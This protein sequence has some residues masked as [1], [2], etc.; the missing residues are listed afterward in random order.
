MRTLHILI[1]TL[2]PSSVFA[3]P[4]HLDLSFGDHR[5][6]IPSYQELFSE[7]IQQQDGKL[8]TASCKSDP[9]FGDC[10]FLVTRY[11]IDGSID[12]SFNETGSITITNGSGG[13]SLIAS[14]E[15]IKQQSD[16][17]LIVLGYFNG[18]TGY[19]LKRFNTDGSLDTTF[20]SIGTVSINTP[21]YTSLIIGY[22]MLQADGNIVISGQLNSIGSSINHLFLSRYLPDGIMD[23]SFGNNGVVLKQQVPMGGITQP[24]MQQSDGKIIVLH[25]YISGGADRFNSDGSSDLAFGDNGYAAGGLDRTTAML[26]QPDGKIIL[27]GSNYGVNISITRINT[28]GTTDTDFGDN[29]FLN[30]ILDDVQIYARTGVL[31]PNGKIIAVAANSHDK[32]GVTLVRINPDGTLDTGFD[33]D[34]IMEVKQLNPSAQ[35]ID[36]NLSMIQSDSRLLIAGM[37][38]KAGE[39][40]GNGYIARILTDEEDYTGDDRNNEQGKCVTTADMDGDGTADLIVG[41]PFA[42]ATVGASTIKRAGTIKIISGKDHTI[43]RRIKGSISNENLGSALAS[44]PDQDSDNIPDIL[45][46]EPKQNRVSLYSGAT[47]ER[48]KTLIQVTGFKQFGAAIATGDVTND[49]IADIVIGAPGSNTIMLYDGSTVFNPGNPIPLYSR[50]GEPGLFGA[51]VAI[52]K[53]KRLL[54]GSPARKIL[55]SITGRYLSNAG[56]VEVFDGSSGSNDAIFILQG[57]NK[58]E[59]FGSSIS[60]VNSDG[61]WLIGSPGFNKGSLAGTGI[62]ELFSN[63]DASPITASFGN[64]AGDGFG[65]SIDASSDINADGI[66]DLVVGS[67]KSDV[68]KVVNGQYTLIKASGRVNIISGADALQ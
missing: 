29:G 45:I 64:A 24:V 34:G 8:V 61:N 65:S 15:S 49:G 48:I 16:G 20:N 36:A 58:N 33:E 30:I 22:L 54:V 52:D 3:D 67:A 23:T 9:E 62:V 28:D 40:L 41:A 21:P 37:F 5:G 38:V 44:V 18:G 31:Q 39:E 17:K 46:G 66:S 19:V 6:F 60:I 56:V 25:P 57:E 43:I 47:G 27:I 1:L 10:S 59:R 42:N 13:D 55:S 35:Y 2:L 11:N 7:L 12:T 4:G 14:A 50:T 53:Q 32:P 26:L 51:S 68:S 63:V